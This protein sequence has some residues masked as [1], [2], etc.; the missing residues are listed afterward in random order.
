MFAF[1]AEQL[2]LHP[3]AGRPFALPL[4]VLAPLGG[5][6][7]VPPPPPEATVRCLVTPG[8]SPQL[9]VS[10]ADMW[11]FTDYA[12]S[13][14]EESGAAWSHMVQQLALQQPSLQQAVQQ[15]VAVGWAH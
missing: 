5:A 10:E 8:S 3:Q 13:R 11:R 12:H 14:G 9:W 2:V 4:A 1:C 6:N 15:Y 7:S